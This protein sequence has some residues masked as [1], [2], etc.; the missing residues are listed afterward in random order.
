[1]LFCLFKIS[2]AVAKFTVALL[3]LVL[4]VSCVWSWKNIDKVEQDRVSGAND[5]LVRSG[6]LHWSQPIGS[7]VIG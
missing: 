3:T 4:T 1:M 7:D 6:V 5:Q 2:I